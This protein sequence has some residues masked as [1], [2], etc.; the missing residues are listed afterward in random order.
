MDL[1]NLV[2]NEAYNMES[3]LVKHIRTL[4]NLLKKR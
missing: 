1:K 4:S 2:D 3:E